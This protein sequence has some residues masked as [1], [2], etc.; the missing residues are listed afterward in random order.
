MKVVVV[1]GGA[2]GFFAAINLKLMSP[3][4]DVTIVE[5]SERVLSKV[6]ISGGGRCNLTNSFDAV[7]SLSKVYPRGEKI[8]RNAFKL[9]DYRATY[10]WFEE[11]G[12]ALVTQDDECVFPLSQRSD[13]IIRLFGEHSHKLNIGVTTR[14]PIKNITKSE[15]LFTLEGPENICCDRVI[16]TTGGSPS[17]RGYNFLSSLPLE[18]LPPIPSLFTLNITDGELS[19][20]MGVV[21]E[22][23]ILGIAGSK[24]R[25]QGDLLVTHWGLSGPAMLRLSSYGAPL[26]HEKEY[27]T[28]IF[29]NWVGLTNEEEILQQL[30]SI[31][32]SDPKKQ[33]G[34]VR[35]YGLTTRIWLHIL[36]RGGVDQTRKWGDL[37]A[38]TLNTI[39]RILTNDLYKSCGRAKHKDEFVTCGGVSNASINIATLEASKCEGLYFAGEVL[40][41]D[42]VTGGFNLQAAW[43]TAYL[44]ASSVA[45]SELSES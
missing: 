41:I 5:A 10:E 14:F 38:K 20:M 16:V 27:C 35:P 8:I 32:R 45:D 37:P 25:A 24:I 19:D 43:S 23:A 21:V 34:T 22:D 2:A 6:R 39:V 15:G 13:E 11:E 44:A 12:V 33:L 40:D 26:L 3:H 17:P 31:M 7:T 18:I 30:R 28:S 29:I 36:K 1:G 9:F 4:L 42:A